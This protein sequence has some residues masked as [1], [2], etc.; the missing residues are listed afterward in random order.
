MIVPSNRLL[1]LTG[2][3]ISPLALLPVYPRISLV[4]ALGTGAFALLAIFDIASGRR[5]L[6]AFRVELPAV[7]RLARDRSGEIAV[8]I[9]REH[10]RLTRLR[11][12]LPM[13]QGL[14]SPTSDLIADLD[15]KQNDFVVSWPCSAERRGRYQLEQCRFEIPSP[16]GLW[17]FRQTAAVASE[18]RVYPNLTAELRNMAALFLNSRA[19][20]IHSQRR[21][22][23]GRD[24]DH[25]RTYVCGD[26][27]ED[28]SWKATARRNHPVTKVYQ[29]E[30]TQEV[31]VIVD[32]SRLSGRHI[33]ALLLK[34][35]S[36]NTAA[37]PASTMLERF[38]T[39][40]LVTG[41]AAEKQ[42]DLFG[43][44]TYSDS[45]DRFVK[46]ANG[47]THF[48]TCRDVLYTMEPRLVTPD[49]AE[50]FSFLATRLHRRALLI[51]LTSLD[52]QALAESFM[53]NIHLVAR[54]HVVMV[55]VVKPVMARPIFKQQDVAG[56]DDLY[57][58]LGGHLLWARLRETEKA[59]RRKGVGFFMLN[60]EALC[61]QLVSQ[62]V[63][64]KQR[65]LI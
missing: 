57:R 34:G 20:G 49:F 64:V 16:L 10:G 29:L 3:L 24:F 14:K 52:D 50:L 47:K 35:V 25:L 55:N 17:A 44:L 7:V 63:S 51:F 60:N 2:V 23:K 11:I 15:R 38:L 37:A 12:G 65:Q 31:Y 56:I 53:K 4:A 59:L 62:Y 18:I 40:A 9:Y 61:T 42:G 54:K 5:R 45:V 13:P 43:L 58:V 32:G 28:I 48:N 8:K 30:R 26:S 36:R 6:G 22:G 46:A 19:Y 1:L 21:I 41:L 39:A 33:P 27:Y